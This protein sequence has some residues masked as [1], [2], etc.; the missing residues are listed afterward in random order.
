V[1]HVFL[2]RGGDTP[3]EVS[4]RTLPG[5][6]TT[7]QAGLREL[8]THYTGRGLLGPKVLGVAVAGKTGTAQ[9]AGADH[10]WFMGY[11]SLQEPDLAVG[12]F[13]STAAPAARSRCPSPAT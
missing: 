2:T 13:S 3:G 5:A 4:V 10:A 6:W 12:S 7:V 11:G 8:V 1:Q 9:N